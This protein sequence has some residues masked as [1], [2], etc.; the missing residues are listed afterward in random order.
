MDKINTRIPKQKGRNLNAYNYEL[1]SGSNEDDIPLP[2]G[3]NDINSNNNDNSNERGKITESNELGC[4]D[5]KQEISIQKDT[6]KNTKALVIENYSEVLIQ[7]LRLLNSNNT[8]LRYYYSS[9]I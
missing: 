2:D 5:V 6:I 3:L 7:K 4:V 9:G 1:K 8:K